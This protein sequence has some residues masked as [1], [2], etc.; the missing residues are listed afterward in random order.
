MIIIHGYINDTYAPTL[1]T[2][3]AFLGSPHP[4]TEKIQLVLRSAAYL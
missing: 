3:V 4:V 2:S 1:S